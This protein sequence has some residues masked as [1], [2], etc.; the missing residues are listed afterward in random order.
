MRSGGQN[1]IHDLEP[2][3][4]MAAA[5]FDRLAAET[6]D[7]PGVTRA[8]YGDGE[9]RAHELVAGIAQ[10]LDLEIIHDFAGN[11]YMTLPGDD[12]SAPAAMIGSH[13]DSVPHGGNYD[14]AAGVVMGLAALARLRRLGTT[15]RQDITVMAIRAEETCWFSTHYAGSRMAFGQLG[16]EE[17]ESCRRMDTGRTLAEHLADA[18]FDPNAARAG[19]RFLD[20]AGIRCFIEPHIEQGPNL[21][22]KSIP[23]GV[24]TGIR[25][26]LRY[27]NCHV[28]G[29]Y[30]HAGAVPREYRRDAVFAATEFAQVLE[31]HWD[32]RDNA[33][34]DFVCTMGELSTDATHHTM[35]KIAGEVRFTMDI[36][37]IDNDVLMDTDTVLRREAARIS[38]ERGVRIDLGAYANG[39][40]G[41]MDTG[42]R[43]TLVDCASHLEIPAIEMAS[44]AG[45][46]CSV[47]ANNG[48]PSAMIFIRNQHGSH[49]PAESME[50]ED[51]AT[52]TRVLCAFLDTLA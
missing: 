47:F 37:S 45:H 22:G 31:R 36:R 7:P 38:T 33:G 50:M 51:F 34:T 44:G 41:V 2:E 29:E 46:D 11:Q 19:E 6:T 15:P 20:P 52:A 40:P 35:T 42:L 9:T 16:P 21:V 24:V 28:E 8:T 49:N 13:M 5:L 12:R 23:V 10:D 27:K 18:G 43:R 4:E 32:E 30:N 25:G 26:T 1:L 17:L 14:G 3:M 48:V 39:K